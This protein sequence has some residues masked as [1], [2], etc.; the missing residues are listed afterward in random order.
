MWSGAGRFSL[1]GVIVTMNNAYACAQSEIKLIHTQKVSTPK[2]KSIHTPKVSTPVYP[3]N[4]VIFA[5]DSFGVSV[6]SS[7]HL[8][9]VKSVN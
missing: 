3:A 5:T 7:L 4:V 6:I 9:N 8:P 2:I 1:A